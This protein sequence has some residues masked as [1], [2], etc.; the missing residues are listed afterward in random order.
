MRKSWKMVDRRYQKKMTRYWAQEE[1][2]AH[3]IMDRVL[4]SEW[5]DY[6]HTH[7]DWKGRANRHITDRIA[8][9]AALLQ[10][11]AR[12]ISAG[13]KGVQCWVMLAPDTGNSALY[14]HS[15]NPQGTAWPH[16]FDG[17]C[18]DVESPGWL[19]PLLTSGL[20]LGSWGEGGGQRWMVRAR[21]PA[22][23]SGI[24]EAQA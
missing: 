12:A 1:A 7:L 14:L 23:A 8:V 3:A 15:P 9:T 16:P 21:S 18:W 2:K 6:W 11:F 4:E 19:A 22:N 17:T 5:Y 10:L 24:S 13:R 20:Q